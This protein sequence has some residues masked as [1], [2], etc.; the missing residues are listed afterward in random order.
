MTLTLGPG[1]Q[2]NKNV[3]LIYW[4]NYLEQKNDQFII[5]M[6]AIKHAFIGNTYIILKLN[7]G[8]QSR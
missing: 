2:P 3:L 4:L 7:E 5:S 1:V 6:P 8:A